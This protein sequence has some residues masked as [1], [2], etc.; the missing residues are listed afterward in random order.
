MAGLRD[1]RV[2]ISHKTV[3]SQT[4]LN[5]CSHIYA[6]LTGVRWCN[7]QQCNYYRLSTCVQFSSTDCCHMFSSTCRQPIHDSSS[8][9]VQ[10]PFLPCFLCTKAGPMARWCGVSH[11]CRSR[12]QTRQRVYDLV[13]P[14]VVHLYHCFIMTDK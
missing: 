9:C 12:I 11:P 13:A 14:T 1:I 8:N 10:F 5:I 3:F 2:G 4:A 7:K 6:T